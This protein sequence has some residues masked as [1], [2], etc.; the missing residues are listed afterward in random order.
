MK[1]SNLFQNILILM[2]LLLVF[3]CSDTPAIAAS[4][5]PEFALPSVEDGELVTSKTFKGKIILINF[6]A[7]WCGP[8]RMEIPELIEL[9]TKYGKQDFVVVGLSIDMG[10]RKTVKKFLEKLSVTYP[11]LMA[12][13]KITDAF[14]G[15]P[16]IPFSFLIDRSGNIIKAYP[17][18]IP[19]GVF[20]HD[21]EKLFPPAPVPKP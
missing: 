15:V 21:M 7:T 3:I 9:Y 2:A 4:K 12:D 10:G 20:Q 14:G 8:C 19:P 5:M 1:Q 6:F 17:G 16:G 18:Y 13:S 11:V